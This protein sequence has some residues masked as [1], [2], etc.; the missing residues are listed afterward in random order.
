MTASNDTPA[1]AR[2]DTRS[3]VEETE[4]FSVRG[5]EASDGMYFQGGFQL[6]ACQMRRP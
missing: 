4:R 5:V 1:D 3:T 2:A 6:P